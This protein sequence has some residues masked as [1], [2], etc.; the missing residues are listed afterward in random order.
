MTAIRPS[1]GP[2]QRRCALMTA[3][4]RDRAD[5]RRDRGKR[6]RIGLVDAVVHPEH[7][8]QRF[9]HRRPELGDDQDLGL[10]R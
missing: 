10:L 3:A 7:G 1:A 2:D 8:T 4:P 6:R 9:H 5:A